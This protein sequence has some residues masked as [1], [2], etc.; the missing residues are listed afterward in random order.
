MVGTE[1]R[2][3]ILGMVAGDATIR[4]NRGSSN[5]KSVSLKIVH[6]EKQLEYLLFKRDILQKLYR[7]WE[8]QI[9]HFDNSGYSG[10]RIN[11]RDHKRLRQIYKLFYRNGKKVF[12]LKALRYLTPIGVA[13]WYMDD[14]SL[15]FKRRKGVVHGRE[16][17][18]NTYCSKEEC[19]VIAGWFENTWNIRWKLVPNKGH[20]RLRMGSK[21]AS[22]LFNLINPYIIPSMAYK[23][24]LKY[25]YNISYQ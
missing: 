25:T 19:E 8:I 12:N 17:H 1:L 21:E 15:S 23:T 7:N 16:V 6:S 14:G 5:V 18:L 2:S 13:I 9:Q 20:Y 11:L 4:K 10:V 24:D 3:A 22:K